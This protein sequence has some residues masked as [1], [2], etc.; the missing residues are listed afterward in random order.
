MIAHEFGAH[1]LPRN[2]NGADGDRH[3]HNTPVFVPGVPARMMTASA[4]SQAEHVY[5]A[6]MGGHYF[7]VYRRTV[8]E[9][10]RV[11]LTEGGTFDATT[12]DVTDLFDAYLMDVAS[13]AVTND[14][15]DRGFPFV[16]GSTAVRADIA[17]SYNFYRRLLEDEIPGNLSAALVPHLPG[18]KTSQ[19]VY[20]D[21][22]TLVRRA[23]RGYM[24]SP[25][26]D[27]RPVEGFGRPGASREI[28]S[29]V[30]GESGTRVGIA[31]SGP[32]RPGGLRVGD[33]AAGAG[34]VAVDDAWLI[35]W[36]RSRNWTDEFAG[37]Q[38]AAASGLV[39]QALDYRPVL[40][41]GE[42]EEEYRDRLRQ[43]TAAVAV[44]RAEVPAVGKGKQQEDIPA[45]S[46]D[47][48]LVS[49]LKDLWD[50]LHAL[51]LVV[52][53]EDRDLV[54][55]R[56]LSIA[57]IESLVNDA[58]DKAMEII[59]GLDRMDVF[60]LYEYQ[61]A[62]QHPDRPAVYLPGNPNH[63]VLEPSETS[64]HNRP[65]T[66]DLETSPRPRTAF[67]E[68]PRG[69][70]AGE[71]GTPQSAPAGEPIIG[72]DTA[73]PVQNTPHHDTTV[74][75]HEPVGVVGGGVSYES[76]LRSAVDRALRG[77]GE[78]ARLDDAEFE[79]ARSVAE[80][81]VSGAVWGRMALGERADHVAYAHRGLPVPRMRGGAPWPN[82]LTSG[83]SSASSAAASSSS[84][85]STGVVQTR[86]LPVGKFFFAN[87]STHEPIFIGKAAALASILSLH[88]GIQQY[89]AG[90]PTRIILEKRLADS[91]AEII[92]SPEGPQITLAAYYFERYSLGYLAGMI[93]HEFGA[94]PL[95]RNMNGADGDRHYHNTPVFVPGVPARMMTASAGSQAEHV[96]AASMGGHY[97]DVY[98][99][100]VIEMAR[101]ILTEGGTFDAT[102]QD[103]TDL[104][105]AYL[106]DVASIAVTNDHR[107]RGF[108]FVPGSTA[109]RA[110]IA[111][112]YNFYRRLLEDEIPG[113]LSAALVP[114][115]PGQK[116]S[117][118][119]Y[120]DYAT[121]VRRAARGYMHSPSVDG[122]PV[123]GFGRPGASREI[124]SAV[125]GESGTRVGIAESGPSRPGGLR[126]G[127]GAAGAGDVA[128]D[129]AWLIEWAR[130]RNWT[131]EFAGAQYAA[132]SG[133][134]WQALDY[135]PVLGQGEAEEEYRDRLRQV[136]A[137]V[138][139]AR[140]EVP[141]V[142]KGKQQED[143]P[144]E[145][146][147]GQL[148]SRLK[149]LWDFLHALNLVVLEEDR[150]L[151]PDRELSIAS[152]ES[153]VNDA[154]DKAM[155]IIPGLDRMD[156][157]RLYEY[158]TALQHPDRPAV[159]L[160][161]NPNHV[162]LEPSETSTHNRPATEDLET[163]PR[164]RTAFLETP[165]G[166]M[167]PDAL[168]I[169]RDASPPVQETPHHD[170]TAEPAKPAVEQALR[171]DTERHTFVLEAGALA[172]YG[173]AEFADQRKVAVKVLKDGLKAALPGETPELFVRVEGYAAGFDDAVKFVKETV[174]V[175]KQTIRLDIG[176]Q[177]IN[178]CI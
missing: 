123:E 141:A 50:F 111:T 33:G 41:Q 85:S 52:L 88:Q 81:R 112:S 11:I 30:V 139:V 32:S 79:A 128:V 23:A 89:L 36:A 107:D 35:E 160:P 56:E 129:D 142:G 104:F 74:E 19:A 75:V 64:T 10:A 150:D 172:K 127:D 170:T 4:G 72:R 51:N 176:G 159:Y 87:L 82:W 168:T 31:E 106:M 91:P 100:T 15:R 21:Y 114:H 119:V 125:V 16:P 167:S 126:V 70:D 94:H 162:V 83:S 161:G 153:L 158:Q 73:A 140:A 25:S 164:P 57:S 138:A 47:G 9:M 55:D 34:D 77:M 38:Y 147:D 115:L 175:L 45:E 124:P 113:N 156:V 178:I 99:R 96:Y 49:R 166:S 29:A 84:G 121:L 137:A 58:A 116:T 62:L 3:Y 146:S 86:G 6:S 2:M 101:V 122:R 53:E 40:G 54:P 46:S 98:R 22:A 131:D 71:Q 80:G 18:Q 39:W 133:L 174:D 12:Q 108:P 163:S 28:P 177:V 109:V 37:A 171:P 60:R 151:V 48:Q 59:P 143:I 165:R 103:V 169:G 17:T 117:Q 102:T 65:A 155:E 7:D 154:A 78:G 149:D 135:R 42:A 61:T 130:S 136:T 90:R 8:I 67:L 173:T 95:P 20:D 134:V 92:P 5:A 93:A 68:T 110:D 148:V 120:D 69:R 118:A 1:P 13:I 43:V 144:A 132:A 105:D 14:H 63:V 26:V 145:S 97:F 66:E 152:I 76:G 27:G 157:F 24:H 44:A